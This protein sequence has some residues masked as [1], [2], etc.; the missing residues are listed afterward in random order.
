[1]LDILSDL[2]S[3]AFTANSIFCRQAL[4][5]GQIDTES[6]T[7]ILLASGGL[8]LLLI[9]FGA[10]QVTMFTLSWTQGEHF[11]KNVVIGMLVAACGLFVL[12]LP[13]ASSSPLGS[14]IA[15]DD[16]RRGVVRL[17]SVRKISRESTRGNR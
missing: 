10:V 8:F 7:A 13:S 6:F 1:M 16:F 2:C 17:F 3:M 5:E 9:L 11:Q 15:N 14:R 4:M 12:L